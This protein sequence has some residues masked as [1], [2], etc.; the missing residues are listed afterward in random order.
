MSLLNFE[1][2]LVTGEMKNLDEYSGKVVLAVNTASKCGFTPQYEGLEEIYRMYKDQGFVVLAFPCNQFGAQEPG[3]E[4]EIH[5]F[6]SC[7]YTITFPV[8]QKIDVNGANQH[9]FFRALKTMA[10]GTMGTKP[11]KWNFTKFLISRDGTRVERFAS[12]KDPE[13]LRTAIERELAKEA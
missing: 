6:L 12:S 11:I 4:E 1:I 10:P 7:N 3:T 13:K 8:F 5:E 2:P 9:P